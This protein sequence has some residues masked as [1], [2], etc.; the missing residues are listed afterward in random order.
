MAD[1]D[2]SELTQVV[3][4]LQAADESNNAGQVQEE[5]DELVRGD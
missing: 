4:L 2:Q 3:A 5:G 1:T